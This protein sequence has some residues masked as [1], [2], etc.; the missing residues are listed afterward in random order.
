ML[1]KSSKLLVTRE[2]HINN[3]SNYQL[4]SSNCAEG[5]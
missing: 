2:F 3:F 1:V 5:T 4:V